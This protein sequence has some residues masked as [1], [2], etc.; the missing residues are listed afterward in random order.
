MNQCTQNGLTSNGAI[1]RA[2]NA[3]EYYYKRTNSNRWYVWHGGKAIF[4]FTQQPCTLE[5]CKKFVA[6]MLG[7]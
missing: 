5:T 3:D 4:G 2:E 1:K 6:M 7:K